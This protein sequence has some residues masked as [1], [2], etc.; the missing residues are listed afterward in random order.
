V[1]DCPGLVQ[2]LELALAGDHRGIV[3]RPRREFHRRGQLGIDRLEQRQ[4]DVPFDAVFAGETPVSMLTWEGS[5][6]EEGV[7]LA[8]NV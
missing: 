5:V 3:A 2:H 6:T 7:V 1:G 8:Q 4:V